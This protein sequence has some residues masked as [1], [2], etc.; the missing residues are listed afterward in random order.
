MK[1][2]GLNLSQDFSGKVTLTVELDKDSIQEARELYDE[3]NDAE[4]AVSI[5][6]WKEKRST[7]ANGYFWVLC[8][9]L[10]YRMGVAKESVY[11]ELI[12]QI[13]N[14]F[15]PVCVKAEAVK[16]L[17]QGWE[18]NGL[19]WVTEEFP[20]KIDGC[21]CLN[22]YYGSSIYDTEQM[23]KL[24]DLA[25][26]ECKDVGIPTDTPDEIAKMKARWSDEPLLGMR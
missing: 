9:K 23:S 21:V 19:G 4:L 7:D 12:K 8:G 3:L 13:G 25:I 11:R 26:A 1:C 18:R 10:A 16:K 5:K 24:I 22:L 17:R 2:R 14:N 15:E 6:K 20:S